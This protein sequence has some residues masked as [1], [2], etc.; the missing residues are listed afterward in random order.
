MAETLDL[1]WTLD[2]RTSM[3]TSTSVDWH[4]GKFFGE[5][6]REFCGCPSLYSLEIHS[7]INLKIILN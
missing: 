1:S 7:S 5:I 2:S 3:T 4:H 6:L